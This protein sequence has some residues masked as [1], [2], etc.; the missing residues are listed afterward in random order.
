MPGEL[1]CRSYKNNQLR[2]NTDK[3]ITK[4][5]KLERVER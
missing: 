4:Q 2:L 5:F 3:D 1:K